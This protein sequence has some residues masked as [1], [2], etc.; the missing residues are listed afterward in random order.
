WQ[1]TDL[2]RDRHDCHRRG[3]RAHRRRNGEEAPTKRTLVCRLGIAHL[4]RL[5]VA[6]RQ[7]RISPHK[8]RCSPLAIGGPAMLRI[9]AGIVVGL[10]VMMVFVMGT[11]AVAMLALGWEGTFQLDSYWTT[12]KFNIIVLIGGTIGAMIGGMVCSLIARN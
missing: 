8:I 3:R 1:G 9:I 12:N 5:T 4:L 7:S 6:R 10:I 2:A 11:F